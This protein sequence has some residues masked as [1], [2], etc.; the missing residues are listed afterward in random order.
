MDFPV[1][2]TNRHQ[3]AVIAPVEETGSRIFFHL[4]LPI[5]EQIDAVQVD[6]EVRLPGIVALLELRRNVRL[7][8]GGKERLS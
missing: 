1:A 8:G 2:V 5:R 7:P 6:L 4:T 3:I